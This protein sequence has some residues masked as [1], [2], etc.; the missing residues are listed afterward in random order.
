[1]NSTPGFQTA[2]C[3]NRKK[4]AQLRDTDTNTRQLFKELDFP[5]NN[6]A[7]LLALSRHNVQCNL[8]APCDQG[9]VNRRHNNYG[10]LTPWIWWRGFLTDPGQRLF[11]LLDVEAGTSRNSRSLNYV[12]HP[13]RYCK[14]YLWVVTHASFVGKY[15]HKMAKVNISMR[16][17]VNISM[18]TS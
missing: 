4:G 14:R 13:I 5:K 6:Y 11:L 18:R 10:Y 8:T 17:K 3:Q 12:V 1:M 7:V 15:L 9:V 2:R 16:A